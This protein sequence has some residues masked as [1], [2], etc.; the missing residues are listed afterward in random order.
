MFV[1]DNAQSVASLEA[2]DTEEGGVR[3]YVVILHIK[4][5]AIFL[6]CKL[7][8]AE[9][10][11]HGALI[12]SSFVSDHVY[13]LVNCGEFGDLVHRIS[14]RCALIHHDVVLSRGYD[15]N[16]S[17]LHD[18]EVS[19]LHLFVFSR[20]KNGREVIVDCVDVTYF[21]DCLRCRSPMNHSVLL[22]NIHLLLDLLY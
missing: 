15:R 4:L 14:V 20:S 17:I 9:Y 18:L 16:H 21:L 8:A 1:N 3:N 7:R 5:L 11:A 2:H 12:L 13:Q 19:H 6:A 22:V 10:Q